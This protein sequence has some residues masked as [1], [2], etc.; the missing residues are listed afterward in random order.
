MAVRH[1]LQTEMMNSFRQKRRNRTPE[2][3]EKHRRNEKDPMNGSEPS[4][5]GKGFYAS[6]SMPERNYKDR[7]Q[8]HHPHSNKRQNNL[9]EGEEEEDDDDSIEHGVDALLFPV[10]PYVAKTRGEVRREAQQRGQLAAFLGDALTVSNS[11][12]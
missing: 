6:V 4:T 5:T 9:K 10:T 7:N 2:G 1:G 3:K 11:Y 12:R 8:T